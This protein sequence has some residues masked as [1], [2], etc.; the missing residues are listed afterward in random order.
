LVRKYEERRP[1]ERPK[2]IWEV[3]I[4]RD[5]ERI[6]CGLNSTDSG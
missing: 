5:A 4:E 6:M 3:N 2:H 1:Y